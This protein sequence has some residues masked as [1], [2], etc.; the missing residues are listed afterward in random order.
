[1]PMPVDQALRY[2]EGK[3]RLS[4]LLEVPHAAEGVSRVFE[5]GAGIYSRGNFKKGLPYTEV[6]D[7]LLRHLMAFLNGEDRDAESGLPHVDHVVCNALFLSEFYR[8]RIE[9]DDRSPNSPTEE[10]VHDTELP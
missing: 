7:S 5:F 9:F 2:N 1:M 4:Y 3:P 6:V 8:T 10:T